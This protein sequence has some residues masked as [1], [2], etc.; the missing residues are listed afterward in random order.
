MELL[1]ARFPKKETYGTINATL[2]LA[3]HL[4]CYSPYSVKA[5]REY[6]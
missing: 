4:S 6:Q 3:S 2:L 5:P 1:W